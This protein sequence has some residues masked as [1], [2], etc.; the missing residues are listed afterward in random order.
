MLDSSP[1]HGK[2]LQNLVKRKID[3]EKNH[4]SHSPAVYNVCYVLM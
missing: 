1:P 2:V 4:Y 3:Y